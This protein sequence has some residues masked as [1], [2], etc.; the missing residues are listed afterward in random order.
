MLP[1]RRSIPHTGDR[2]RKVLVDNGFRLPSALDN[3]PVTFDEFESMQKNIVFVS[4][5]P[6]KYELSLS[7]PVEQVV[8]P[9]GLL[10]PEVEVRPL[11]TQVDDAIHEIRAHA[12]RGERTLVTTLTKRMA[13]ELSDYLRKVGLQPLSAF[14]AGYVRAGGYSAQSPRR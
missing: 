13:E 11:A 8:R 6:G 14:G 2:N 7:V 5:T 4:A 12:A 3:R 1:C 10:D 9:T